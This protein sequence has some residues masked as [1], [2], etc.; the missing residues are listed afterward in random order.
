[1]KENLCK[2]H[3]QEQIRPGNWLL[4]D[5]SVNPS[6][7]LHVYV[8]CRFVHFALS[9]QSWNFVSVHSS[10]SIFGK[11][12]C[13][14]GKFSD[15]IVKRGMNPSSPVSILYVPSAEKDCNWSRAANTS[16]PPRL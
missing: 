9:E 10:K 12:E 3:S 16:V 13:G 2:N 6:L 14:Y 4:S 11:T 5:R 8:P 7:Q 1:M 15:T